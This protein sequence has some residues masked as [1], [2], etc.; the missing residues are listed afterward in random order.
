MQEKEALQ[1]EV[2][3]LRRMLIQHGLNPDDGAS[4][5]FGGGDGGPGGGGGAPSSSGSVSRSYALDSARGQFSPN[6]SPQQFDTPS[7]Q[8]Q[9]GGGGGYTR[10]QAG[11][12]WELI[13]INFVL[14]YAPSFPSSLPSPNLPLTFPISSLE[15]PCMSHQQYLQV[16]A[17]NPENQPFHHPAEN[18]DDA[19]HEHM[20]GHALMA[21]ATP[22]SH[23]MTH[24]E[25]PYEFKLV[26][27]SDPSSSSSSHPS[28]VQQQGMPQQQQLQTAS[29]AKLFHLWGELKIDCHG[30]MNAIMA[31]Q[32]LWHHP[33][34]EILEPQDYT[35]LQEELGTKSRCYGY[36]FFELTFPFSPPFLF[37][38]NSPCHDS[39]WILGF[40]AADDD[41]NVFFALG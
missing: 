1:N 37:S 26:S 21:S 14:K 25:V 23:V 3:R 15:R 10:A 11:I 8:H 2:H 38:Q 40:A 36:V 24:P 12:D 18:P 27:S 32:W 30:E 19:D 4:S 41:A 29:L 9:H 34:R 28:E 16:R 22:Y 33:R 6:M 7:S 35:R 13:G 5:Q 31:W 20:S 39:L 17:H